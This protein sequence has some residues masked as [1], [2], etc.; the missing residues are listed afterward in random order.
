MS[1]DRRTITNIENGADGKTG[2]KLGVLPQ[3]E[4]ANI[5]GFQ[6]SRI[7]SLE[8]AIPDDLKTYAR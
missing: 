2:G 5:L 1:K 8:C 3:V 7:V 6:S 4:I